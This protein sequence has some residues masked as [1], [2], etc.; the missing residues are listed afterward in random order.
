MWLRR[1]D[2]DRAISS[3]AS[4]GLRAC[5]VWVFRECGVGRYGVV[6]SSRLLSTVSWQ[7]CMLVSASLPEPPD[8][9]ISMDRDHGSEAM[10][11]FGRKDARRQNGSNSR[12][13]IL[14]AKLDGESV[15]ANPFVA[16]S[17]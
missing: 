4:P 8:L 11:F 13:L 15:T 16:F 14:R 1:G 5:S 6:W 3:A 10:R 12:C 9:N 17:R 7:S 2:V